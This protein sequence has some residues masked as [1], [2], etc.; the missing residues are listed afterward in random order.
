MA[1]IIQVTGTGFDSNVW[2]L[3]PDNDGTTCW[4]F[5][6]TAVGNTT[7]YARFS[8]TDGSI[9]HAGNLFGGSGYINNRTNANV[10]WAQD[11]GKYY[12]LSKHTGTVCLYQFQVGSSAGGSSEVL[13]TYSTGTVSFNLNGAPL[14]FNANEV[15]GL[16]AWT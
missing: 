16:T 9:V 12:T 10:F 7:K 2:G 14:G 13:D 11:N 6:D 3:V 1:T 15:Y 8:L 4:A 5:L